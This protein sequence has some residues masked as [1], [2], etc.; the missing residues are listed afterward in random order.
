VEPG[1]ATEEDLRLVHTASYIKKIKQDQKLFQAARLAAGG[2]IESALVA[3]QGEKSFALVRPPG[4]H[5]RSARKWGFCV[6]NNVAIAVEK[7]RAGHAVE[8]ALILDIDLHFGDGTCEI[9]KNIP[10]VQY[11]HVSGAD[12]QS[13]IKSL[14]DCLDSSPPCDVIAVSAGFDAH[15]YDWGFLLKTVDYNTMGKMMGAYADQACG[16]KLFG[17]LEGG[18]NHHYLGEN[19]KSFL[20]GLEG[21]DYLPR[22]LDS[23]PVFA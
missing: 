6:F 14:A 19:I 8:R 3:L 22:P 10:E 15:E 2:A 9:Y 18:Y 20:L 13:F 5:A 23:P 12:R 16:G 17:V 4:H 11:Y 21:F 1:P 7:L